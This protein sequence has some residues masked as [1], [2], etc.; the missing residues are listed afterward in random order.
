M[1]GDFGTAIQDAI[2]LGLSGVRG[3]A[4]G[5][6]LAQPAREP[7]MFGAPAQAQPT[8]LGDLGVLQQ[9]GLRLQNAVASGEG[10]GPAFASGQLRERRA[11][12]NKERMDAFAQAT[13]MLEDFDAIRSRARPDDYERIDGLLKRRFGEVAGGQPG[14]ADQFYDTFMSGRGLTP[15]MLELVRT[16]P[17]AQQLL[18]GGAGIG[19]LRTYLTSP[20]K[21][22]QALALADQKALP[23][24]RTK[25]D[26]ALKTTDPALRAEI[27]RRMET[28]GGRP[29]LAMLRDLAEQLPPELQPTDAEWAAL[30]RNEL[31]LADLG[32]QANP[33]L[34][35]RRGEGFSSELKRKEDAARIAGEHRARME[36]IALEAALNPKRDGSQPTANRELE[37]AKW[38]ERNRLPFFR[39]EGDIQQVIDAPLNGFGDL[40]T[41]YGFV[42][43]QDNTAAREGELALAQTAASAADRIQNVMRNVGAGRKLSDKQRSEI[44]GIL[45]GYRTKIRE[46]HRG[47]VGRMLKVAGG[48]QM[49]P[50]VTIPGWREIGAA[51]GAQPPAGNA[52]AAAPPAGQ[53]TMRFP[54]GAQKLVPAG[55]VAKWTALG[56]VQVP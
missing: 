21:V 43:N 48:W 11:A 19:D 30:E 10:R 39:T 28:A 16:D 22:T 14:D 42:K 3:L 6:G 35:K 46:Q 50:D 49:D 41:L 53:V 54:D 38:I 34:L 7:G 12:G 8:D 26:S 56:G 5:L 45:E 36:Q 13:K 55:E 32:L 17:G 40:Q 52:P 2:G 24:A 51:G 31:E 15:G 33:E 29:T 44:R 47:F 23:G 9:L 20:E 1:A 37:F 18:A 27:T 4:E 25:L